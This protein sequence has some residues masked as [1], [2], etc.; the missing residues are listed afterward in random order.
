MEFEFDKEIDALLRQTA[1]GETA[2]AA[3]N[4]QSAIGNSHLDADAISAFAENALPEKTRQSYVVHFADC[5]R[6]RKILSN[7]ILSNTETE[8]ASEKETT[9]VAV[10]AAPTPWYRKLFAYP[11]LAYTMGALILAFSGLIAFVVLQNDS[12]DAEVSQ[13]SE[14]QPSGKGMSS[15][16]DATAPELSLSNSSSMSSASNTNTAALTPSESVKTNAATTNAATI[17][18]ARNTNTSVV[19]NKPIV[20]ANEVPK[21][22][23]RREDDATQ[24]KPAQP[25]NSFSIDGA[26]GAKQERAKEDKKDME[27]TDAAKLAPKAQS[28]SPTATGRSSVMNDAPSAVAK[29]KAKS[30]AGTTSVGGKTFRRANG[31]WTDSA[32]KGQATTNVTRG[33]NEYK[34]LD[35]GLRSIA[36]NL[37]GTVV[38]VWKE[39]AYRIQ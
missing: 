20:S 7:V 36:D 14:R 37:G 24:N 26:S 22:E 30:D 25:E 1:K 28:P 8:V 19:A 3:N 23:P 10:V 38:I 6:C 33:T 9:K 34:K 32:Y 16:G 31:V 35:S 29:K 13:I 11:N 17:T 27:T 5:E 4:P 2:F 21:D 12:R 15:D 18:A 39:K